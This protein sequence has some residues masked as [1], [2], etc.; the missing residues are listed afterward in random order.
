VDIGFYDTLPNVDR[1]KENPYV[2][3]REELTRIERFIRDYSELQERMETVYYNE[4]EPFLHAPDSMKAAHNL[5]PPGEARRSPQ[6]LLEVANHWMDRFFPQIGPQ[7]GWAMQVATDLIDSCWSNS[8]VDIFYQCAPDKMAATDMEE[9][10][11]VLAELEDYAATGRILPL[12]VKVLNRATTGAEARSACTSIGSESGETYITYRLPTRSEAARL[13]PLVG[14]GSVQWQG[15]E[16][17]EIWYDDVEAERHCP[18]EEY[19]HPLYVNRPGDDQDS[20]WC[21]MSGRQANVIC[22]ASTG[23]SP[24]LEAP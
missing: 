13:A 14:F 12:R 4:I 23:P 1:A 18:K 10:Q 16:P 3:I 22:V 8:S 15:T 24:L 5:A 17:H 11:S 9:W 21:A 20:W 2:T 7:I 19:P 6:E